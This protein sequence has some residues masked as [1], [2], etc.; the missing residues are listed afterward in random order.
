MTADEIQSWLRT[1]IAQAVGV[2]VETIDVNARFIDH[3]LDSVAML[4][5]TGELETVLGRQLEATLFFEHPSIVKLARHLA[6]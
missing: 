5:L 4:T 6:A 1:R 2:R 3:G